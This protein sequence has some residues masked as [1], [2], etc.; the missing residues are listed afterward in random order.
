MASS[1]ADVLGQGIFETN[2]AAFKFADGQ[3]SSVDN[4]IVG[5]DN[6]FSIGWAGFFPFDDNGRAMAT[7]DLE[8]K[9]NQ[10]SGV[11]N[12]VDCCRIDNVSPCTDCCVK[13]NQ[14]Q[15][16]AGNRVAMALGLALATNKVKI[17]VSQQ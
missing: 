16:N 1:G 9:K 4:L 12:Q 3:D 7:N 11:C 14:D 10:D 6:A 8:I 5:N 17:V 2:G 13:I 15:I